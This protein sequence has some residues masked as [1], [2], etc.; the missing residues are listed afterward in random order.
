[1]SDNKW[2]L[3][4]DVS[5]GNIITVS[6]VVC[7]IIVTIIV[8]GFNFVGQSKSDGVRLSTLNTDMQTMKSSM[9]NI[10]KDV[11]SNTTSLKIIQV[12]IAE[13]NDDIDDNSAVLWRIEDKL[14]KKADK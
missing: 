1:M 10:Q 7:T 5:T 13:I 6:V 8:S 11:N 9:S 14:D 12:E 3:K 2:N 4:K